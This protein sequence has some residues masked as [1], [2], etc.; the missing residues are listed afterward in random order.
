MASSRSSSPPASR[1]R[2]GWRAVVAVAYAVVT[3]SAQGDRPLDLPKPTARVNDYAGVLDPAERD[4]L[5][6]EIRAL[7]RDTSAEVALVTVA[8]LGGLSVEDYAERLFN[9][10]GIGKAAA[11]NGVLV[12][13]SSG[14]RQMRIEVGYGLEGVLP[15]GLAGAVIRETFL[16]EFRD[17]RLREGI[18]DGTRRVI[19]IVRRHE[20][21]TVEQRA[22]L[23]AAAADANTFWLIAWFMSIF[24]AVGGF[25]AGT[26][27]GARVVT[28][29]VVGLFFMGIALLMAWT[30]SPRAGMWML[31]GVAV[32]AIGLGI[33]LGRRP[34]WRRRI[35]GSS[36]GGGSS[37]DG[38]IS[39]SS[40]SSS[41]SS[42][43]S[44]S[45]DFGGGSS[46]GGGASGSW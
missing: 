38:W 37:S 25:A 33:R 17:G 13:V 31:Y 35:R 12:L 39:G 19:A 11:D 26:A 23:D 14:D 21:L 43:S 10:W 3:L 40:S 46:G 9:T 22:A 27:L 15:D 5:E 45:G 28:Q 24:V 30:A 29:A 18:L 36:G 16:P 20:T 1:Q 41:G 44:S 6:A 8:S 32:V 7:D 42:D 34:T 2:A 4:A